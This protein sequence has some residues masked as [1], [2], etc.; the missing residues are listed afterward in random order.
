MESE[1]RLERF[2]AQ[3]KWEIPVCLAAGA[4]A[5]DYF[6]PEALRLLVQDGINK[7][8]VFSKDVGVAYDSVTRTFSTTT[9]TRGNQSSL[10]IGKSVAPNRSSTLMPELTALVNST[11]GSGI[12]GAL[13]F[14]K[15][16]FSNGSGSIFEFRLGRRAIPTQSLSIRWALRTSVQTS[17]QRSVFA[18]TRWDG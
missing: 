5:A 10:T 15:D 4:G 14:N 2:Q 6:D 13:G 8:S 17:V 9:G 11:G 7:Q 18:T 1:I 16:A 3:P 12:K